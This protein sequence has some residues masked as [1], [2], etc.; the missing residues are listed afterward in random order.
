[1]KSRLYLTVALVVVACG[2]W[3]RIDYKHVVVAESDALKVQERSTNS[4]SSQGEPLSRPR[5]GL[6]TLSVLT[7]T[8]YTVVIN[9]PVNAVAVVFL[10]VESNDKSELHLRGPHLF[11]L[12]RTSGAALEGYR[13]S[14]LVSQAK[15]APIEFDVV[16]QDG[17]VIGRES[18]KYQL[19]SRG[20]IWAVDAL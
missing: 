13:S 4:T 11:E 3:R 10:R 18:I 17:V 2:C 19:V 7:R 20:Y 5:V 1:M 15:G 16:R 14:F 12:E 9:T 6:P 8:N